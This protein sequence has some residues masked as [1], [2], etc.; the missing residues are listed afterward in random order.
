MKKCSE[1][2]FCITVE[3]GYSNYTVE[4][5]DA[6]CSKELN[7]DMPFDNW[8][9]EDKRHLFAENCSEFVSGDRVYIDCDR[10]EMNWQTD[11]INEK[12]SAY[13]TEYVTSAD[14]ERFA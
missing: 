14:I 2:V 9:G 13:A 4:G 3:Y 10:E 12:W 11:D 8:F 1:C 5:A 7:P 6:Y